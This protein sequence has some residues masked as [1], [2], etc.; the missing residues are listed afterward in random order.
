[1]IYEFT[2]D[3][4]Q[5]R[6]LLSNIS[7]SRKKQIS[8]ISEYSHIPRSGKTFIYNTVLSSFA[9]GKI[10]TES[11]FINIEDEILLII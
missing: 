7:I 6:G 3:V 1:M 11:H 9:F 8:A 2:S 10:Q 5:I 4:Y